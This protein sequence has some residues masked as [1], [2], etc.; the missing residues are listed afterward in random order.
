MIR[1]TVASVCSTSSKGTTTLRTNRSADE[2]SN[3]VLS[4]LPVCRVRAG[5]VLTGNQMRILP[6]GFEAAADEKRGP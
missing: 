6:L 4:E 1:A 2:V 3:E 5:S